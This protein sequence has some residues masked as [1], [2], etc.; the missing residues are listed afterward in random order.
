MIKIKDILFEQES[1]PKA[2]V[3]AGS[4]GAGKTYL[5]NQLDINTLK[6]Y[7]PDKYVEDKDHPYH[8]NLS[9]A[10][11]QVRGQPRGAQAAGVIAPQ[12]EGDPA[13]AHG[14]GALGL[15]EW[16][17]SRLVPHSY[18]RSRALDS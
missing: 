18:A 4:A 11:G 12:P 3:M 1:K 8:N 2:I 17:R 16:R 6:N 5:L 15:F 9:A 14:P 13:P 10:A 7:N